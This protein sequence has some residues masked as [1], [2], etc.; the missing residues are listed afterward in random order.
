MKSDLNVPFAH[1][2]ENSARIKTVTINGEQHSKEDVFVMVCDWGTVA[3]LGNDAKNKNAK[4]KLKALAAIVHGDDI[5]KRDKGNLIVSTILFNPV[6][7]IRVSEQ[8]YITVFGHEESEASKLAASGWTQ[9]NNPNSAPFIY[10]TVALNPPYKME[11][12]P[13]I[14]SEI[15]TGKSI[16]KDGTK[17]T[18]LSKEGEWDIFAIE[19]IRKTTLKD[20]MTKAIIRSGNDQ[21]YNAFVLVLEQIYP[22]YTELFKQHAVKGTMFMMSKLVLEQTLNTLGI[23]N[24]STDMVL[25]QM[26]I[27]GIKEITV[28]GI[29]LLEQFTKNSANFITTFFQPAMVEQLVATSSGESNAQSS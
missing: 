2:S 9:V 12:D 5:N 23:D 13:M 29:G 7:P 21:F 14:V 1:S 17:F 20:C 25:Q 28:G 6:S 4:D 8:G 10:K 18:K 27:Q 16:Y 22:Q 19:Q 15:G 11:T 3:I 24:S 26:E